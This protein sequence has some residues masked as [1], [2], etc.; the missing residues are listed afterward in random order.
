ML[1]QSSESGTPPRS[2]HLLAGP[3]QRAGP[4]YTGA[5]QCTGALKFTPCGTGA[6]GGGN[7]GPP[8]GS[9]LAPPGSWPRPSPSA[10]EKTKLF[11]ERCCLPHLAEAQAAPPA[12][13]RYQIF[14]LCWLTRW[15]TAAGRCGG[16]APRRGRPDDDCHGLSDPGLPRNR[17]NL[18]RHW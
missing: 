17:A 6:K 11:L 2:I 1:V 10:H 12:P 14:T 15:S 5:L 8:R 3:C 7:T 4:G 9:V 16:A 18:N 13:L